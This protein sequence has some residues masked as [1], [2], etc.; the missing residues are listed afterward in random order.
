MCRY[1]YI[2]HKFYIYLRGWCPHRVMVKALGCRIVV[3]LNS[4]HPIT[5]LFGQIPL[6]KI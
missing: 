1:M 3:S 6:G 2:N 5:F 4:N